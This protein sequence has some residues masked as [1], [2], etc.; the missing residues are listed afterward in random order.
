MAS[1]CRSWSL[2]DFE[3]LSSTICDSA[4]VTYSSLKIPS[5]M[6]RYPLI[7]LYAMAAWRSVLNRSWIVLL[8]LLEIVTYV[9]NLPDFWGWTPWY[10]ERAS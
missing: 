7:T 1:V 4:W 5:H 8:G 3:S 2:L 9:M 10:F 6:L